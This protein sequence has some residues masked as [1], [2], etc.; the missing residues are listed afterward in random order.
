MPVRSSMF[1]RRLPPDSS[2]GHGG[3]PSPLARCR[4]RS[5]GE[6]GDDAVERAFAATCVNVCY[7]AEIALRSATPA[8]F[9]HLVP[10]LEDPNRVE[11]ELTGSAVEKASSSALAMVFGQAMIAKM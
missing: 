5:R 3:L 2:R 7:I 8:Y 9:H 4:L 10:I 6:N 1:R 11:V